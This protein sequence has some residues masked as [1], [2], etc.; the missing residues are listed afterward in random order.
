MKN[1]KIKMA[2]TE[3]DLRQWE[4]AR[5]MGIHEGTLCRMLREELPGA[6]Q[7]QIVELIHQHTKGGQRDDE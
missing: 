7:E 4:L 1:L 5:L 6:E 2:M 3:A